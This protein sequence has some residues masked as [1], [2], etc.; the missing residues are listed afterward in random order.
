LTLPHKEERIPNKKVWEEG[1]KQSQLKGKKQTANSSKKSSMTTRLCM[2]PPLPI[3]SVPQFGS[4]LPSF[5][6]PPIV[7][8]WREGG[9]LLPNCAFPNFITQNRL[10]H[11]VATTILHSVVVNV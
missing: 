11:A 2:C 9:L 10:L 6:I 7:H 1:I 3:P 5:I 4:P 8:P